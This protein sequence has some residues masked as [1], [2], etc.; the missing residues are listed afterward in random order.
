MDRK[1]I[2]SSMIRSIGHD[3]DS[4]ILE[5]EFNN[6]AVWQYS[7]FSESTWYEFEGAVSQGKF[8]HSDI[9]GQYSESQVG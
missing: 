7:D 3:A 4:A 6:G 8:F 1:I 9:K 5:I 2:E